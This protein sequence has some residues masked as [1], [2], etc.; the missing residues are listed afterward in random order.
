M[1]KEL[2][3]ESKVLER[4]GDI[5]V[6]EITQYYG[7][8]YSEKVVQRSFLERIEWASTSRNEAEW[9]ERPFEEEEKR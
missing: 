8:L 9:S 6:R 4:I 2:E 3:L 7:K 5:I 1:I